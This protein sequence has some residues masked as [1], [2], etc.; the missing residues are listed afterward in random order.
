MDIHPSLI[1][2]DERFSKI[3]DSML[4]SFQIEGIHFDEEEIKNMVGRIKEDL[5]K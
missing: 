1:N 5:R 3:L 2:A 4:V